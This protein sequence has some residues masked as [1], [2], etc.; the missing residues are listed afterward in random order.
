MGFIKN[1]ENKLLVILEYLKIIE[2][3]VKEIKKYSGIIF[4]TLAVF[5]CLFWH[6]IVSEL[7]FFFRYSF[8]Y[9]FFMFNILKA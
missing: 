1:L 8:I 7:L 2:K 6:F 3:R 5:F 9:F 4:V